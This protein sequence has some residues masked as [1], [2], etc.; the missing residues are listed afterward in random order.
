MDGTSGELNMVLLEV[1]GV[2]EVVLCLGGNGVGTRGLYW[3]VYIGLL[4]GGGQW[5]KF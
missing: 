3:A 5:V 2:D 1:R 4:G